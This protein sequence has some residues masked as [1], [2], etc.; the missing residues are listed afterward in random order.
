M[1]DESCLPLN[2]VLISVLGKFKLLF[3]LYLKLPISSSVPLSE[4]N[5]PLIN[6]V[7]T[8]LVTHGLLLAW[9]N[10]LSSHEL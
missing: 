1:Q 4:A 3:S 2:L 7:L 8:L 5:V 9:Q 6:T 10:L